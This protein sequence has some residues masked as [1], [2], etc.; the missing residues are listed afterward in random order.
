MKNKQFLKACFQFWY[1]TKVGVD[2]VV[3]F[4][5]VVARYTVCLLLTA[6]LVARMWFFRW[7]MAGRYKNPAELHAFYLEALRAVCLSMHFSLDSLNLEKTSMIAMPSPVF[8]WLLV[9]DSWG[10][11]GWPEFTAYSGRGGWGGKGLGAFVNQMGE[12]E[13]RDWV[14]NCQKFHN[15]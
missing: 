12:G 13:I 2:I 7:T 3:A 8:W 4:R 6:C 14:T 10:S 5:R 1:Y 9:Q 15:P 11:R